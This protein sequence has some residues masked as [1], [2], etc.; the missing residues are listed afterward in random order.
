MLAH[1]LTPSEAAGLDPRRVPGFATEV[2]GRASHTAIVAAA[3]EIPAVAGLGPVL[4]NAR[5]CRTAIVDGDQGLVILDPDD[6]TQERYRRMAAERSARFQVLARQADRPDETL[7][8][9]R[10]ELWGNIEF[11]G[12]VAACLERGAAGV[13]LFRTEFLFLNADE[14]PGEDEQFEAYAAV[15]R[16]LGGRPVTIRTLDLGAD[17]IAGY[18]PGWLRRSEP[19]PG[20]AQPAAVAPRPRSYSGRSSAPCSAPRAGRRPGSCSPWCPPWPSYGPR[21]HPRRGRRRAAGRGATDPRENTGRRH[22]RGTCRRPDGRSPGEG[23]GFLLHR[24]Q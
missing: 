15:V 1:D 4:H 3:L 21:S 11:G 23:G 9:C 8:G 14:P 17:K 6:E 2:G 20:P 18:R 10:V 19:G 16:A 12:E 24:N 7:D 13:G 5:H 22:G